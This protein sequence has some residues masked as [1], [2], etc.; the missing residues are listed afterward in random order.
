MVIV[1]VHGIIGTETYQIVC[2]EVVI[3][4]V[5]Y[6][7]IYWKLFILENK[8]KKSKISE[9]Q[10]EGSLW[11]MERVSEEILQS[12]NVGNKRW[13]RRRMRRGVEEEQEEGL[14]WR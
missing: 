6:A 4:E 7:F 2:A 3:E 11:F 9:G 1:L 12:E 8:N 13:R 14:I 10:I 5:H